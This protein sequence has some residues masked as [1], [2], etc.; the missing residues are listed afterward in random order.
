MR[1]ESKEAIK[2][3]LGS[4]NQ[5][6]GC[7]CTSLSG[8]VGGLSLW[9]R[10]KKK[11]S[12]WVCDTSITQG[13]HRDRRGGTALGSQSEANQTERNWQNGEAARGEP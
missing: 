2:G 1:G 8:E 7:P 12:L 4:V 11:L 3:L 6:M 5:L 10:W 13:F 9:T